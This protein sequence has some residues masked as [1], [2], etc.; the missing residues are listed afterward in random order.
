MHIDR[1]RLGR[2]FR[3]TL[4][5]FIH[6]LP[7]II[8]M[9]LLTSLAV[10]LFPEQIAGG[11]FGNGEL[12]DTLTA[13][14]IGS[15]AAGHPLASYLLGG[16]LLGGGVGLVAVSALMVT[17]VTVGMV[18]LP[19]E[20]MLLGARFAVWRNLIN[21][22]AAIGVAFSTVYTLRALGLA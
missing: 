20:A 19:A 11:L 3:K 22:V 16:E 14:V 15:I 8:G 9:L 5:T 12:I 17:W 13:A 10:T 18:Q 21:F 2:N 7:V 1:E 4:R 6:V